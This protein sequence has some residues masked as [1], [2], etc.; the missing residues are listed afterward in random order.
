MTNKK[1]ILMGLIALTMSSAALKTNAQVGIN[2]ENPSPNAA[3][4]VVAPNQDKGVIIPQVPSN[5]SLG[6]VVLSGT[7]LDTDG[8]SQV[9]FDANGL[10]LYNQEQGCFNYYKTSTDTWY[11]LCGTPPPAIGTVDC[12]SIT[13]V[14]VYIEGTVFN[15]NNYLQVKINVTSPGTYTITA[16]ATESNGNGYYFS[17]NGTFPQVGNY[18]VN[19]IGAG[20]PVAAGLNHINYTFNGMEQNCGTEINIQESTPDFC[21][22]GVKQMPSTPWPINQVFNPSSGSMNFYA[23]VTLQVNKP[24]AYTLS[25]VEQNGYSFSGSGQLSQASGYNPSGSFPQTVI[26]NMP[27]VS[28]QKATANTPETN[29]FQVS[30]VG[31][32]NCRTIFPL[33]ITLAQITFTIDCQN[34]NLNNFGTLKQGVAIPDNSTLTMP[35]NASTGGTTQIT[36]NF[37][38]LSF[39]TGAPGAPGEITLANGAQI[40]TL[41]PVTLG[42]KPNQA[43]DHQVALSSSKGGYEK[44]ASPKTVTVQPATASFSNI[45]ISTFTNQNQYILNPYTGGVDVPCDMVLAVQVDV[46]GEYNLTTTVNG[47]TW[48]GQGSVPAGN[49]TVTLQPVNPTSNRPLASGQHSVSLSYTKITGGTPGAA[50][51]NSKIVYFVQRSVNVLCLGGAPYSG[52]STTYNAGKMIRDT[53]NFGP[54]GTVGVQAIK[55]FDGG[56]APSTAA[57]RNSINNNKIDIIVVAYNFQPNTAADRQV[58]ADFVNNKGGALIFSSELNPAYAQDLVSRI[59]GSNITFAL[60]GG[61]TYINIVENISDPVIT[62]PFVDLR[63]KAIGNDVANA[64]PVQSSSV[65]SPLITLAKVQANGNVWAFRH[66]SKGFLYICD[67]G[68]LAGHPTASTADRTIYPL[69]LNSDNTPKTKAYSGENTVYNSFLWGNSMAW[70]ID[71][72]AA[73]C[74]VSYMIP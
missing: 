60:T 59:S 62:G 70:A 26:V 68:W 3:L 65:P 15:I 8:V 32:N 49:S 74:N 55:M 56:G 9:P 5:V 58:L 10:V 69:Q 40:V 38:G 29:T 14:G 21:I 35:V 37:A 13:A 12:S 2:T 11:S 52:Y 23:E 46:A 18:V 43:G 64:M 71:W 20:M 47:V 66:P 24:G 41:Y 31:P 19:L 61:T 28:G 34:I 50:V 17:S 33:T 1:L 22:I 42:Q 44:C 25:T 30:S 16:V 27:V 45:S 7:H 54:T 36:A 39:S 48:A 57:L 6:D 53:K 51:T 73:H 4:H 67:S 72:A 63:G